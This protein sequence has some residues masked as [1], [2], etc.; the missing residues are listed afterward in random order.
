MAGYWTGI[1]PD[2]DATTTTASTKVIASA[3]RALG[4]NDATPRADIDRQFVVLD[5]DGKPFEVLKG[6]DS[7]ALVRAE[8]SDFDYLLKSRRSPVPAIKLEEAGLVVIESIGGGSDLIPPETPYFRT[9]PDEHNARTLLELRVRMEASG[10]DGASTVELYRPWRE[11]LYLYVFKRPAS[12][13]AGA[14]L[15][16]EDRLVQR[17][18]GLLPLPVAGATL[19]GIPLFQVVSLDAERRIPGRWDYDMQQITADRF[20]PLLTELPPSL[21]APTESGK[22]K[23][24]AA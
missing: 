22:R 6:H 24:R 11:R 7:R 19:D 4:L 23:K 10:R 15:Q 14:D 8:R 20:E 1:I 9:E 12:L 16:L 2:S 21:V 17:T 13:K 3:F 5:A 18:S